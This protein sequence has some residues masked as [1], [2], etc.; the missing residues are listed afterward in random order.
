LSKI[1]KGK[2]PNINNLLYFCNHICINNYKYSTFIKQWLLDNAFANNTHGNI[3]LYIKRFINER[4]KVCV[5]CNQGSTWNNKPLTLQIDHI[6][7]DCGNNAPNNLRLLCPNCHTQTET[8]GVKNSKPSV[9]YA[10]TRARTALIHY[11]NLK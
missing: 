10:K 3:S 11:K 1:I 7:G 4:D 2:R 5:K 8:Y 9:R 6:D